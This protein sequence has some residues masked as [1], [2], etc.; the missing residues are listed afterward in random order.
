LILCLILCTPSLHD[1]LPI[2]FAWTTGSTPLLIA[3]FEGEERLI[4]AITFIWA[5]S[6]NDCAMLN[7]DFFTGALSKDCFFSSATSFSFWRI[8][9]SKIVIYITPLGIFL[10]F[11]NYEFYFYINSFASRVMSSSSAQRVVC[12]LHLRT[13]SQH[14]LASSSSYFLY[15]L[16]F[17]PAHTPLNGRL[18]FSCGMLSVDLVF[19]VLLLSRCFLLPCLLL[20][21]SLLRRHLRI[22]RDQRLTRQCHNRHLVFRLKRLIRFPRFLLHC[23]L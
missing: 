11:E 16:R 22:S 20:L 15:L 18:R 17:S 3:P 1:A 23:R 8:I 4:S 19:P 21:S 6:L 7:A 10:W 14:R 2:F 12:F 9:L 5:L 13:I